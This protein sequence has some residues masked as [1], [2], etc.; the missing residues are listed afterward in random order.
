MALSSFS[1]PMVS[2]LE[3][4][5][6][7]FG[8]LPCRPVTHKEHAPL[9][10]AGLFH[11]THSTGLPVTLAGR[12][13]HSTLNF[14]P[15]PGRVLWGQ[16]RAVRR[17]AHRLLWERNKSVVF[18]SL[19][20]LH[21]TVNFFDTV[22]QPGGARRQWGRAP[23]AVK[24]TVT[25]AGRTSAIRG[26]AASF[27]RPASQESSDAPLHLSRCRC[28]CQCDPFS[29]PRVAPIV[30][31]CPT[32]LNSCPYLLW[33]RRLFSSLCFTFCQHIP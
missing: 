15:R 28:R 32:I 25:I 23:R 16:P 18:I 5:A 10:W 31:R 27:R 26:C 17:R 24:T 33:T 3:V 20:G 9:I 4:V 6:T 7:S 8:R 13:G 22:A 29:G 11:N 21:C 1:H 19:V 30:L 12:R 2:P 14:E